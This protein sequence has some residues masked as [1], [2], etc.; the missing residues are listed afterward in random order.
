MNLGG[1]RPRVPAPSIGMNPEGVSCP[2]MDLVSEEDRSLFAGLVEN[3]RRK[4]APM[5]EARLGRVSSLFK[6]IEIEFGLMGSRTIPEDGTADNLSLA[7]EGLL[8]DSS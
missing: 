8:N 1:V 4:V 2:R 3:S 6:S 5:L 7:G